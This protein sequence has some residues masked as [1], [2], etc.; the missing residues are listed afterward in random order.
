[1]NYKHQI[2]KL[3]HSLLLIIYLILFSK[4]YLLLFSRIDNLYNSFSTTSFMTQIMMVQNLI[5]LTDLLN[6]IKLHELQVDHLIL[7][8]HYLKN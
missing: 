1:M 4:N 6:I 3:H 2:H 5:H 8:F 7:F